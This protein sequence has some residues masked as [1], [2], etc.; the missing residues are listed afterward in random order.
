M[1]FIAVLSYDDA[2]DLSVS[3]FGQHHAGV[4]PYFENRVFTKFRL[5]T[6]KF[7]TLLRP[8]RKADVTNTCTQKTTLESNR[9][10]TAAVVRLLA[11][12]RTDQ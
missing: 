1:V 5:S 8:L 4:R 7:Q 3:F 12:E 2:G 11:L 9:K 6:A 10:L